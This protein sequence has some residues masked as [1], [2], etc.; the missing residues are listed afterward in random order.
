MEIRSEKLG[1]RGSSVSVPSD[2]PG[3]GRGPR[4]RRG[5]CAARP[6]ALDSRSASE[7]A[8]TLLPATVA[9]SAWARAGRSGEPPCGWRFLRRASPEV[10]DFPGPL[11]SGLDSPGDPVDSRSSVLDSQ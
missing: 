11:E 6:A 9:A 7:V 3:M 10:A 4:G 8:A 5:P 2:P 1:L